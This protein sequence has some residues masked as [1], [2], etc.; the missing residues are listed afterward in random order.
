MTANQNDGRATLRDVL[1]MQRNITDKLDDIQL[2]INAIDMKI[3]DIKSQ[4]KGIAL[5]IS[6]VFGIVTLFL[7]YL[8]KR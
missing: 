8:L 7:S 3:T 1:E 4:A 5:A 2:R 6:I